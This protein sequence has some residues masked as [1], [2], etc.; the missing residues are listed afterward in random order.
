MAQEFRQKAVETARLHE[1]GDLRCG[2]AMAHLDL[3][4]WSFASDC[5]F[6][7]SVLLHFITAGAGMSS[8]NFLTDTSMP[9]GEG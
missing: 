8:R 5:W 9:G 7:A 2:A 3:N 1:G 4:I 6:S